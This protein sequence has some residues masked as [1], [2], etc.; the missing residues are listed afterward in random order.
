MLM[1]LS[2]PSIAIIVK[3]Y[4]KASDPPAEARWELM[5]TFMKKKKLLFCLTLY[6][7]SITFFLHVV[8]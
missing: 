7:N 8:N 5:T 6:Y 2:L 1:L 4:G 3:L